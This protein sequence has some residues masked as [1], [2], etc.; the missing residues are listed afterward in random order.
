[1]KAFFRVFTFKNGNKEKEY[2]N[3]LTVPIFY[4]D[5][6]NEELDTAQIVLDAM[7]ISSKFIF[8]PKTKFRIERYTKKDFT[9]KPKT[10]DMVVE[11]D[12]VEEYVGYPKLCCH[13]IHLIEPSVIAQ[14]MHIDNISLTYELQDVTLNYK[15]YSN[16]ET[17]MPVEK[18]NGGYS[19]KLR[20][21]KNE[22][23]NYGTPEQIINDGEFKNSYAYLWDEGTL[24]S[25]RQL[26]LNLEVLNGHTISFEIPRLYCYGTSNGESWDVKLFEMNTITRIYRYK[27]KN[28]TDI[29]YSSK[30]L[31]I[32]KEN[33]P[34]N[35]KLANNDYYY[36][37]GLTA[38]LRT[39]S[40]DKEKYMTFGNF[41]TKIYETA[42]VVSKVGNY[43][44]SEI[45]FE[46]EPLNISEI[47]SG[48]GY[49]F[50]IEISVLPINDAGLI[51]HYEIDYYHH[52]YTVGFQ[53]WNDLIINSEIKEV[54]E[55]NSVS[56]KSS[57]YVYDM[58][59]ET[60]GGIYLTKGTKYSC[61]DLLRKALLT[62][63]SQIFDNDVMGLDDI[64]YCII[65]DPT[66]NNRL[67]T[68][69][70]QETIF[71]EKN[72]WEVLLQIGYYLHAIPYLSF[73]EDGTDRFILSFK[74]LGDTK[75]K[76]DT[77]NK[78]T[79]FNSQ[80]LNDYF[81]Q[82]D[83]YVTN[84]F[85][86]QNLVDEWLTVKSSGT[87]S[88][89]SNNTAL[90]KTAYGISE[91]VDFEI[92]YDG[93]N[94]G[95]AGTA[96]ALRYI[97]EKSIY[98]CL[99]AD[100][101][102]SPSKADSI[103]YSLG[104]DTIEGL[105]YIAPSV[106]N[107]VPMALK[108]IVGKLFSGVNISNLKFNSLMFH[109]KYRTQDSMRVSQVRPDIQKFLKNSSYEKYPHHE[110]F[111]NSQDK[112]VDSERLSLNLFGKL[113]RVGNWICQRQEQVVNVD[114]IK[115][116]G[117]L[118]ELNNETYYVTCIENE[119]YNDALL[120]K[121]TYSKNYN[122]LSQIVTIPSEPRFYEVS[123]RSKIRREKRMFD[124]FEI[125]TEPSQLNLKPRYLN[126]QKWK[127]FIKGLLFNVESE[128]LPN[129]VWTRFLADKKRTHRGAYNQFIP[130]S[131]MFPSS[132]LDRTNPNMVLP[133]S[134]SDHADC[135]VPL[136]HFPLKDG[137]MFEW[138][139]ED[140]FK[141]GDFTDA[142]I[143]S[144]N[145]SVDEAY[146]AQQSMRY[147]D[148]L[149]RADLFR[150]RL[151]NKTN[152]THIQSQQLPKA[153]IEPT[154]EESQALISK[155]KVE[156]LDK[157]CREEISF[158]YQIQLTYSNSNFITFSN[159]FGNK[160]GKLRCCLLDEEVSMFNENT[161]VIPAVVLKDNVEYSLVD[162]E[163]NNQIK[164][165]FQNI[166]DIDFTKMKSI[167]FYDIDES[168]N[169]VSYIAK[170]VSKLPNENK[171][172]NLYIYPI[173]NE[174]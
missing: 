166:E 132:E 120:Q 156:G 29:D 92:T 6:L 39:I 107:D 60:E 26:K 127:S 112:I 142:S 31:I 82:Y 90:L 22:S 17:L 28:K 99:T 44:V 57:F 121:V 16:D 98:Q 97:F 136:L 27:T 63:D 21:S 53:S 62:T 47:E 86:P 14:G 77:S 8:P 45:S 61:Y 151:F 70:V 172:Q 161:N 118:V 171:L 126:N 125:S 146:H 54:Q 110:Q 69:K 59:T 95:T 174:N 89:I 3:N 73:A 68:C 101:N 50:D 140:N 74:Q 164:I 80:N 133:V 66:W 4:E 33:G 38:S 141:A 65:L 123:E 36:S 145:G 144:E 157:D 85:S 159:L 111:H 135:I 128:P 58:S 25:L 93:S 113:I 30:T 115:E 143:N 168:E 1:M 114:D 109:I 116:S 10:Y 49:Y 7:P 91:V 134:S 87:D 40:K 11:H 119:W 162:D 94:G 147:C 153:C 139:M 154:E 88:L 165:Q 102:I 173:F 150:F 83:S 64:E 170:N 105:N 5:R 122:Q 20:V 78:I 160:Q 104:S 55:P 15:T 137:I 152:F 106:N 103:Y 96:S 32:E 51:N 9:D 81:T 155:L 138:D 108:R 19:A 124:F 13:R 34:K 129:Y 18:N 43:N 169:K 130:L 131:Q 117:D 100:N 149:G 72:L 35:I 75:K 79:I 37:D 148:V 12:D 67:K 76:R 84:L 23:P 158:N 52:Y 24:N 163:E 56:I 2:T 41:F 167:V 71:E 46:T 48:N 42:P